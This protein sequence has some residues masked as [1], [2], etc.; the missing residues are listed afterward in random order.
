[1]RHSAVGR[2]TLI[3]YYFSDADALKKDGTITDRYI[4]ATILEA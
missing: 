3:V 2:E 4:A 1:M